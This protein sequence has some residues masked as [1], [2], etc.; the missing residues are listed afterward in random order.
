VLPTTL[1]LDRQHRIR[2][3]GHGAIDWDAST[4]DQQLQ[5]LVK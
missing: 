5:T 2:L 3:R 4:I 1:T